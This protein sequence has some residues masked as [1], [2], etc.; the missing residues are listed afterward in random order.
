MDFIAETPIRRDTAGVL[1]IKLPISLAEE[2]INPAH[3]PDFVSDSTF[4]KYFKGLYLTASNNLTSAGCIFTTQPA[5][6][7][8]KMVMTYQKAGQKMDFEFLFAQNF[9]LFSTISH[10]FSFASQDLQTAI[11]D[12]INAAAHCFVQGLGGLQTKINFDGIDTLFEQS[13]NKKIAINRAKLVFKI[14]NTDITNFPPPSTLYLIYIDH[15]N[16]NQML[17]NDFIASSD[18]F[19]G[20]YDE[21][22][23]TFSFNITNFVQSMIKGASQVKDLYLLP[24]PERNIASPHRVEFFANSVDDNKVKLEIYYSY[25]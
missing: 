3:I 15:T 14:K 24:A 18:I 10:D 11:S 4:I 12:T 16:G 1:I 25:R 19:D 21:T 23:Q 8:S 5:N 20:K 7:K 2:F 9:A 13:D 6:T 17:I 22:T